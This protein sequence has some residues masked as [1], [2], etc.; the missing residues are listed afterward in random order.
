M[1]SR[2]L[3]AALKNQLDPPQTVALTLAVRNM[4]KPDERGVVGLCPSDVALP[5][6]SG[7][8]GGLALAAQNCG[9]TAPYALTGELTVRDLQVF[10]VSYCILGHSER[11]L[12]LGETEDMIVNRLSAVLSAS[13]IPILCVGETLDQK[14]SGATAPVIGAQLTSLHKA[15]KAAAIAPDPA[16]LIIAYEPMWAISTAGSNLKAKPSDA[17]SVH[18]A[19]RGMLDDLFGAPFGAE[20]SVI[21]G[22]GINAR[23]AASFLCRPQIDGALVGGGM[24]TATGF[25]GVLDAFYRHDGGSAPER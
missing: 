14:R 17:V 9:W 4:I 15:F 24:Q 1:R 6:T 18:D 2:Y 16:K 20:T 12:Y 5:W 8:R 23:N 25:K 11:R 13:I 19:I 3:F 22:G 10:S 7:C 21:F